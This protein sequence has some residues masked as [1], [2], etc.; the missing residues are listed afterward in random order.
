MV[1]RG[2]A[3]AVIDRGGKV[4]S[5]P[6]VPRERAETAPM[7]RRLLAWADGANGDVLH[8]FDLD[9]GRERWRVGAAHRVNL[10]I[11]G[12]KSVGLLTEEG[13]EVRHESDGALGFHVS[14]PKVVGAA[15]RDGL[16]T[17]IDD[18]G[19]VTAVDEATDAKRWSFDTQGG[20][21]GDYDIEFDGAE[22]AA[23]GWRLGVE[24]GQGHPA[25]KTPLDPARV[26]K[27]A[28]A[29]GGG[30][31]IAD[32]VGETTARAMYLV[33]D[34]RIVWRSKEWARFLGPRLGMHAV[35]ITTSDSGAVVLE[36]RFPTSRVLVGFDN[37]TG[38]VRFDRK[39]GERDVLLGGEGDCIGLLELTGGL[40]LTCLDALTGK[41]VWNHPLAGTV[42]RG[43]HVKREFLLA[44]GSPAHLEALDGT[45]ET[46]WS[47]T[48]PDTEVRDAAIGT[49][50]VTHIG[51]N[52]E[53]AWQLFHDVLVL[54]DVDSITVVDLGNGKAT[55]AKP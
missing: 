42:A 24:T 41:A 53:T 7:D 52:S 30:T 26:T 48:L 25:P 33:A 5:H 32:A 47:M 38:H 9:A 44:S 27:V 37:K 55:V 40:K 21:P 16:F 13:I 3:V 10:L 14:S 29:S 4:V 49:G 17:F 28:A 18:T 34:H 2:D 8:L 19:I 35:A 51:T 23:N 22:V 31:L 1:A 15:Y 43:W 46:R 54:P 11:F 12:A 45:G 36:Y 20:Y 39:L 6:Q 50:L